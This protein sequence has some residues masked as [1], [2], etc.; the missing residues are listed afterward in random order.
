MKDEGLGATVGNRHRFA[1]AAILLAAFAASLWLFAALHHRSALEDLATQPGGWLGALAIVAC[2][3]VVH[4][5]LHVA[6]WKLLASV[7]PGAITFRPT[8]RGL[9]FAAHLGVTIPLRAYRLGL[10]LPTL[11][12]GLLP[13]TLGLAMGHGLLLLWGMF[14]LLE[15]YADLTVLLAPPRTIPM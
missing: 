8:W 13:I 6:G 15:C 3:A 1:S 9:G 14:F 7:P 12:L 10:I 11:V 5:L 2:S 4:E